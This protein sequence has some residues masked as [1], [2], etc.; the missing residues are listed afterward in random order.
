MNN[1]T[2]LMNSNVGSRVS[3][4]YAVVCGPYD[5]V[6]AVVDSRHA[7]ARM[8]YM[9]GYTCSGFYKIP[10]M[11]DVLRVVGGEYIDKYDV[12]DANKL[13]DYIKTH[14]EYKYIGLRE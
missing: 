1:R 4:M 10:P 9:L 13:L 12:V 2:V 6:V 7:A 8:A 5:R 14:K 11:G 3:D